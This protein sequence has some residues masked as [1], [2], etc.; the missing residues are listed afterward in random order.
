MN[1]WMTTDLRL[2]QQYFSYIIQ[3]YQHGE[4]GDYE[5]FCAM[6]SFLSK[7]LLE[8]VLRPFP[9]CSLV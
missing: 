7:T 4:K 8:K 9:Q 6:G 3:L 5:W 2:F 1:G